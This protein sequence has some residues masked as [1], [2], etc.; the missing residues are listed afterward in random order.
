M[1]NRYFFQRHKKIKRL[2]QIVGV[3]LFGYIIFSFIHLI[4]WAKTSIADTEI[5]MEA[6]KYN[7]SHLSADEVL[8]EQI[9]REELIAAVFNEKLDS[10][11]L[12]NYEGVDTYIQLGGQKIIAVE[13][14]TNSEIIHLYIKDS[15]DHEGLIDLSKEYD[16]VMP[17]NLITTVMHRS[18][19][20]YSLIDGA[21]IDKSD[22]GSIFYYNSSSEDRVPGLIV[23]F[24]EGN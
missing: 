10:T 14:K 21:I 9:F 17:N 5:M 3:L 12:S 24:P 7:I 11:E 23:L 1:T 16:I 22:V 6:A 8:E 19:G 20:Y 18:N 4:F 15:N 2:L 13:D